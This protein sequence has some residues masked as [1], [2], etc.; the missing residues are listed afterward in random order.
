MNPKQCLQETSNPRSSASTHDGAAFVPSAH[1]TW[2][3]KRRHWK[4][5]WVLRT[6]L[7]ISLQSAG[8]A[9][10]LAQR[11]P[12]SPDHPWHGLG[13]ARIEAAARNLTESKLNFDPAKNYPLPE[14]I[15]LAE[16]HN[17][18][19]RVA[20]NHARSQ[21]AAWAIPRGALYPTV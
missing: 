7:L 21:T 16:S 20:R 6:I 12:V 14:L 19:T 17:P 9:L 3:L 2:A 5:R 10:A 4:L 15:D 1:L 11:A 13:E 18:E 8:L